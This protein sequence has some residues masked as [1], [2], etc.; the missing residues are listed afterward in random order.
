MKDVAITIITALAV[1]NLKSCLLNKF[2]FIQ[3]AFPTF[4][5]LEKSES[6]LTDKISY[7]VY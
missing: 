4:P 3:L 5:F 1:H 7:R 6:S 2:V